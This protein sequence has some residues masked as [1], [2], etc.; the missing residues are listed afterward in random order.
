MVNLQVMVIWQRH[1][2][3]HGQQSRP[4]RFHAPC[5]GARSP[6]GSRKSLWSQ[7]QP[8]SITATSYLY[9][10]LHTSHQAAQLP[11]AT[12]MPQAV[13]TL[14]T[15]AVAYALSSSTRTAAGAGTCSDPA[16]QALWDTDPTGPA[17]LGAALRP[18]DLSPTGA[19]VCMCACARAS[20]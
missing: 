8:P 3:P 1:L 10:R 11:D 9:T 2:M 17:P 12:V 15:L 5:S 4:G 14:R 13:T 19:C 16:V 18:L 6:F 20:R 7:S